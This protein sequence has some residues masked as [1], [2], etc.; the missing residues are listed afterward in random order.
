MR[1]LSTKKGKAKP[2][3]EDEKFQA[4]YGSTIAAMTIVRTYGH[5]A[6]RK[7]GKVKMR[8]NCDMFQAAARHT[9][10]IERM[11]HYWSANTGQWMVHIPSLVKSGHGIIHWTWNDNEECDLCP[12]ESLCYADYLKERE[13]DRD[14]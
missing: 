11:T 5:Q 9:G 4:D 14:A 12:N 1:S 3:E 7:L 10:L 13:A 8:M 2:N 6:E